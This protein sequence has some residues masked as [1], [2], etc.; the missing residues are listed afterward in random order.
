MLDTGS[1]SVIDAIIHDLY[2]GIV[3]PVAW[4]RALVAIADQVG[5]SAAFLLAL[6]PISGEVLRK[7]NHRGDPAVLDAYD[8]HWSYHDD[9]LRLASTIPVGQPMTERTLLPYSVWRRA[10]ILNEFLIPADVPHFM[11]VTLHRSADKFTVLSLQ[12][13]NKRGPFSRQDMADFGRLIPHVTRALTVKDR[14]QSTQLRAHTLAGGLNDRLPFGVV[15]LDQELGI[16]ETNDIAARLLRDDG[17]LCADQNHR[18]QLPEPAARELRALTK[19]VLTRGSLRDG[20]LKIARGLHQ[21]PLSLLIAPMPSES[22]SWILPTPRWLILV[23][24]PEQ[25]VHVDAQLLRI[26]LGITRREADIACLLTMGFDLV[27]AAAN[28]GISVHTA[29]NQLKSIFAKTG[30]RS[31]AELVKRIVSGPAAFGNGKR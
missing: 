25:G 16:L 13:T 1:T 27:D 29:R 19:T 4:D 15:L 8:R 3:D 2:E 23:F 17:G 22:T 20:V 24:D 5:G 14:L 6:N 21:R 26:D 7:E 11:P 10:S 12:G 31:Q 28:C 30:L 18:L 9:R